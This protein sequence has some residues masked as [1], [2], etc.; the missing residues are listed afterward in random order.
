VSVPDLLARLT[1]RQLAELRRDAEADTQ[2]GPAA[3]QR[4]AEHLDRELAR[5]TGSR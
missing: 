4:L 2:S 3:K 1:P 5:R